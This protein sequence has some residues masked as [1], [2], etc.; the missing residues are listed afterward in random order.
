MTTNLLETL[1]VAEERLAQA[2]DD[3]SALRDICSTLAALQREDAALPWL[4]RAL[5]LRPDDAQFIVFYASAL[6]L[7]GRHAEAA[8]FLYDKRSLPWIPGRLQLHLGYSAMMAG[9]L[10]N[11]IP[12]LDEARTLLM[13]SQP[14]FCAKA[15][16]LYGEALLKN[17]DGAGF[18]HWTKRNDEM[19][20]A[21]NFAIEGVARWSSEQDLSGRRVV[22][23][24]QLGFGDQFLLGACIEDWIAAGATVMTTCDIQIHSLM[25]SSLPNCHVVSASRPLHV[26][27]PLP[28]NIQREVER[29]E[30]DLHATLLFVPVLA[31]SRSTTRHYRF[32]PF[33]R[34]PANKRALAADWARQLRA[35]YPGKRLVGIFWDCMP[36]H[37]PALGSSMRCWAERRSVPLEAIDSL[38]SDPEIARETHFV[39]LHHPLVEADAGSPACNVSAYSPGI[40]HFDDT[41]ACIEQ[42]DAVVAVDSA[43]SN[44]AAMMG[45]LTCVPVNTSGDWRWGTTGTSS[46][47]IDGVTVLRQSREGDWAP[48]MRDVAKWLIAP[49]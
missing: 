31:A 42:L 32:Q 35:R 19:S 20:G 4:E 33:I 7:L 2:P 23:T 49:H 6:D 11:A 18:E 17:G 39:N 29:F 21:G 28:A 8:A 48:V 13:T 26:R 14:E 25:Q 24:H 16:H 10:S 5:A 45:K 37:D 30:P 27:E 40:Y 43:V 44:L 38:V 15:T 41:A 9:D 3:V 1:H 22:I 47:W 34:T 36:R 12:L 46:P